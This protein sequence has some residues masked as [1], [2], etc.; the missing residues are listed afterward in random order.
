MSKEKQR[1]VQN[2]PNIFRGTEYPTCFW[3]YVWAF[4]GSLHPGD[5]VGVGKGPVMERK[6]FWELDAYGEGMIIA[7]TERRKFIE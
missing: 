3:F 1:L 7:G 6:L 5:I 4:M 2:Q